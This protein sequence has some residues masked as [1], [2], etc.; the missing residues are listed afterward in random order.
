MTYTIT[1]LAGVKL[2]TRSSSPTIALLTTILGNDGH[3]WVYCL[4]SEALAS[5]SAINI[6]SL[7]SASSKTT[8]SGA[9]YD[10]GATGNGG[11]ASGTYFYARQIAI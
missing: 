6:R 4:A 7:G 3:K 11:A 2:A 8:G 10:M 5:T 9:T 1:P